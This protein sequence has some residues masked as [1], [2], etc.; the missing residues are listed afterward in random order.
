MKWDGCSHKAA[1][2]LHRHTDGYILYLCACVCACLV[3]VRRQRVCS[4]EGHRKREW[5]KREEVKG[6]WLRVRVSLCTI[7]RKS[8]YCFD[9]MSQNT[10]N[11]W[12]KICKSLLKLCYML[13]SVILYIGR[14]ESVFVASLFFYNSVDKVILNATVYGIEQR[15]PAFF[16]PGTTSL[17]ENFSADRVVRGFQKQKSLSVHK[18]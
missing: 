15:P 17:P 8:I 5:K 10:L 9:R 16:V 6:M 2:Q 13:L 1:A 12:F 18:M 4:V 14:N 3:W 11:E 7:N